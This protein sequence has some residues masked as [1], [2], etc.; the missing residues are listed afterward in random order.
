LK[1]SKN[2]LL[3]FLFGLGAT[4][5][6]RFVGILAI[7]DLIA[8]A[9]LPFIVFNKQMYVDRRFR[10]VIVLL[11]LW[12]MSAIFSDIYNDTNTLDTLKGFFTLVPFLAC[13]GFSYWLLNKNYE[14]M[15]PFLWGYLISYIISALFGLDAFY[16]ELV[17]QK[18]LSSITQLGHYDKIMVWVA[19]SFVGGAFVISYFRKYPRLVVLGM[20]LFSILSLFNGSRGI[21]L[22]AF[23][24]SAVLFYFVHLTKHI[25]WDEEFWQRR[26]R[27]KIPIFI[28]YTIII[29]YAAIFVYKFSVTKGYL[30]KVELRKYELETKSS[31]GLL[32]SRGEFV[33]VF[34]AI[35][36]S[37]ILGHGSYAKDKKGY[38]YQ[39]AELA[40]YDKSVT[41]SYKY[42]IGEES[43]PTHSALWQAWVY[44]GVAGGIFW[45]YIL[46]WILS[47]FLWKY[48]FEFPGYLA[49]LLSSILGL[50]WAILFSPF[51][52]KPFLAMSIMFLIVLMKE[53]DNAYSFEE[54]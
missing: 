41:Q 25:Q 38:G 7:S 20:F 40:G 19:Y 17:K 22:Q 27:S 46:I 33:S 5:S 44:N 24:V 6:I 53:T 9:F 16:S 34:L 3:S 50:F 8:I 39:A 49:Y 23:L 51:S 28:L 1:F 13:L 52:Q 15:L 12:M 21:F 47:K 36:D 10:I 29:I 31:I 43:I 54:F 26:L 2:Q 48:L 37:P 45:L 32:S 18:G 14:L 42:S 30:G 35:K 11:L 4:V